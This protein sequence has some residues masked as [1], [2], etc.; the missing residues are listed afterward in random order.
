MIKINLLG[1]KKEKKKTFAVDL[2]ALKNLKFQDLLKAGGEYYAGLALWVVFALVLV[3][4]WKLD[5]ERASLRA[6]LDRLNAEKTSLQARANKFLEE[7]KALEES[8]SRLK[9]SIQEIENSKDIIMGLKAYYEPFSAGLGFYS[10]QVP[11]TAWINSYKQS[12]DISKQ[13]LG[14]ELEIGA[15]DYASLTSYGKALNALPGR[16]SVSQ[17][18]RKTTPGGFE[19]Y[20]AKLN[21]EFHFSEGR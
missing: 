13:T 8:I 17:L 4:Y 1:V 12:L 14:A 10:S 6:E 18:E 15:L 2:T 5:R 19:Y 9:K 16:A 11:R 20:T 3:Y 21:A 7:K